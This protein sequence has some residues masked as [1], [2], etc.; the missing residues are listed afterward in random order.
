MNKLER[1][2][3]RYSLHW[4]TLFLLLVG[5]QVVAAAY[6]LATSLW[7]GPWRDMWE[8][9]PFIEKA[10]AGQAS[11]YDYWDQYGYSH[12][13]FISRIFWV[14][15]CRWFGCSNHLLLVI[16]CLMQGIIFLAIRR[17]LQ[18]QANVT[19]EQQCLALGSVI[20]CLFNIT[21]VFNFLHTFDVQW[22]VTAA[23]VVCCL[24]RLLAGAG[25]QSSRDLVLA[26]CFALLGSLNNFSALLVWPVGIIL[27]TGLRYRH[28]QILV[29]SIA[30][31]LYMAF[32]F[33]GLPTGGST[34]IA[35]LA[36]QDLLHKLE[37][38]TGIL[39]VF[40]LWYLSNPLSFQLASDGP[41]HMSWPVTWLAPGIVMVLVLAAARGGW[42]F[43]RRQTTGVP[44]ALMGLSL[45][46]YGYGVGI[47]TALGR[48]MFWD[49][50][51]A[52]R[53]QN[54]VLLFWIGV[55]LWLGSSARW[56]YSGLLAATVL[57]LAF[58]SVRADWYHDLMLKTGN[59]TR[60]AH[61]ALRVGL[62]NR[63]PAIQATVSR[64]HLYA[65]SDYQLVNEAAFLRR[66]GA[67][68]YGDPAWAVPDKQELLSAPR[69]ASAVSGF[70][71]HGDDASYARLSVDFAQPV[72]YAVLAWFD[73]DASAPGLL[74]AQREDTLQARMLQTW[75]GFTGYAGFARTLPQLKPDHVYARDGEHWCRL[76][77]PQE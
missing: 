51:Y 12:R 69:C 28:A 74:I 6:T 68:P 3:E 70:D 73:V 7:W 22:F 62:E 75:S 27:M 11:L 43:M 4:C 46:L 14:A 76:A 25:R 56:R 50:V 16:S 36:Q 15:D 5:I 63:L 20:F 26:W 60:D 13:P 29:F 52:L 40:P 57:L 30:T 66:I 35:D 72:R 65:G 41:L 38:V 53:Y 71:V 55:V 59:R 47:V 39:V 19:P 24:E 9:L 33:Q 2:A 17:V 23:C 44:M 18:Q 34:V 31:L 64:S 58:F 42:L 54:I 77:F 1:L 10:L 61:L 37:A 67:G 45:M 49:N 8:A 32:Y 21:Q 48:G